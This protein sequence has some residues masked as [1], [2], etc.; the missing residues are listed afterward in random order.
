MAT[1]SKRASKG[2]ALDRLATRILRQSNENLLAQQQTVEMHDIESGMY[3]LSE[4]NPCVRAAA[5]RDVHL[6]KDLRDDC[7]NKKSITKK[8][9]KQPTLL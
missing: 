9:K 3:Q 2:I 6:E 7:D 8:T 5:S 4:M 1:I